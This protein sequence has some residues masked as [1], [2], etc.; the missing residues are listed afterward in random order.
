MRFTVAAL[1]LFVSSCSSA[2]EDPCAAAGVTTEARFAAGN[3]DGHADPTGAKAASQA[4][5]GRIKDAS[6]IKRPANAKGQVTV[7]DYLLV[8]DKIAVYIEAAGKS[9]SYQPFGGEIIGI[10]PVGADGK[11]TGTSQYGETLLG[12]SRQA[13]DAETVTVLADGSDG[14]EAIVRV[15]GRF[16]NIPFLDVFE[17]A[18]PDEFNFPAALDYVLAPGQEKVLLRLSFMNFENR[19]IDLSTNQNVGSFH[20]M[21]NQLFVEKTGFGGQLSGRYKW[22][23]YDG[24]ESAFIIRLKNSELNYFID[25]SGFTLFQ[26]SGLSV[27]ACEQKTVDYAEI[28]TGAPGIDGALA[29]LARTDGTSLR[30]LRGTVRNPA[31]VALPGAWV[32]AQGAGDAYLTRARTDANG[33]FVLHVPPGAVTLTP[34]MAGFGVPA[35]TPVD[36][37]ANDVMLQ[38]GATGTLH[39]TAKDADSN[40]ALPVRVQVIPAA[41]VTDPPRSFGIPTE[42][43]GRL[44]QDFAV[45]GESTLKV[46]PGMH[47][48]IVSRGFEWELSDQMVNVT[49]DTTTDVAVTLKHGVDSTGVMCADFHIH[50]YYS[51]DS[52]DDAEYK[53]R[54]AIADGLEI[55]VSSEHEWIFNFQPI[56]E[57]LGVTQWAFGFP[58]EEFTTF[59]WGHF[60]IIPIT[61]RPGTFNNGAVDWI[62]KK[63]PEVFHTIA[64]LPENPV[65]I[66]NH[67]SGGSAA[68]AYLTAAHFSRA[69]AK[70]DPDM[71]SEEFEAIEAFNSSDYDSNRNEVVADWLAL[72]DSGKKVWAVGSSDSHHIRGGPVGYPRTCM[73]FGHDDPKQLTAEKVRDALRAGKA[74]ISGG[75]YMTVEGPGGVGPGGTVAPGAGALEFKVVVQAPSWLAAE[76]LEAIVDGTSAQTIQLQESVVPGPARRWEAT[77]TV[78]PSAKSKH[79][80]VFHAKSAKSAD[81]APVNPGNRPFAVSNPIFY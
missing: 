59:A 2:P 21:R 28:I 16:R 48:V 38:L 11:P 18:S 72:L 39:V 30:E 49:A 42:N 51:A 73:T 76:T 14:K 20:S 19:P 75:L 47:R 70:G 77:V 46:P 71:W 64:T 54:G 3:A 8:N 81:L 35:A 33:A 9:D 53:V 60:G 32:H 56:I 69:T 61:P 66:L 50:S 74:T 68:G 34:T 55:P 78:T 4:R 80:V 26:G 6:L 29:A 12:L 7:G 1:A 63:P 58:S 37:A 40:A 10:E 25:V 62:G 44:H 27:A 13:I 22:I 15:S 67:P 65:L 31:G 23:G 45:S 79:Y 41:A 36:G 57:K 24:G 43:G 17:P 52:D 5:A